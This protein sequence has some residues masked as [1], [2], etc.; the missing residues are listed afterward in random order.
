MNSIIRLHP[1]LCDICECI[2]EVPNRVIW[3]GSINERVTFCSK[4]CF[5]S[6]IKSTQGSVSSRR[7]SIENTDETNVKADQFNNLL[8]FD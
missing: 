1:R 3:D 2:A 5:T 7:T 8:S 6:Y 4:S